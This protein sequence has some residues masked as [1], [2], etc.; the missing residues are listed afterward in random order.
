MTGFDINRAARMMRAGNEF[1][2]TNRKLREAVYSFV[3]W[4]YKV[5]EYQLPPAEEFGW[6][7]K[8]DRD[9]KTSLSF[10]KIPYG[11]HT[12]TVND[13]RQNINSIVLCCRA[14]AEAEGE[15]LIAWL[16]KQAEER[17][18]MLEGFQSALKQIL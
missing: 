17:K 11:W 8:K 14:L 3:E 12:I 7:I 13:T 2:E 1:S 5:V 18:K 6:F 15:K 4:L 10:Q 16:E 9:E